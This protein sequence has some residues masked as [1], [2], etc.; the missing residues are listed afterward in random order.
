MSSLDKLTIDTPEQTVLEFPLAGVGSRFVAIAADTAIQVVL[1]F[2]LAMI[3]LALIPALRFFGGL[4]TQW[5]MAL[6]IFGIFIINSAYFAFFE[7][8]WNGQT[9][10][11]RFAQI[12][13]MKDD[14]RPISVYDAIA[15][16]VLR[17]V[18]QLPAVYGIAIISVLFSEKNKR[19]G[20][21]VAGTV[22]VHEKTM[23]AVRPYSESVPD[24]TLPTFDSSNITLEELRLIET[25]VQRRDSLDPMLR[26]SMATQIC[27]RI[28]QKLGV[29]VYGWPRNEKFLEAVLQR[30]RDTG[31]FRS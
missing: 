6:L 7:S 27:A 12:R 9:P 23:E 22:V 29:N 3:L 24:E 18:D 11:K 8:I 28:S 21:F 10:G 2:F 1:F 17:T 30:C 13:V 5:A 16:N 19:L 4:S 14:G 20:D 25:F 26:G 15:R 31:R